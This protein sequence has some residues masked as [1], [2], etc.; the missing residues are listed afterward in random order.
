MLNFLKHQGNFATPPAYH[1]PSG[2]QRRRLC[3]GSDHSILGQTYQ[4][5]ELLIQDNASTDGPRRLPGLARR[6]S[7][8]SYVRTRKTSARCPT[9]IWSSSAPRPLLQMGGAR[10][11]LR[12]DLPRALRRGARCRAGVVLCSGQTRLIN[13]D[14]SPVSYDRAQGRHVTRDR[15]GMLR[16]GRTRSSSAMGRSLP[17]GGPADLD[18]AVRARSLHRDLTEA[19]LPSAHAA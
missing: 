2:F 11:H 9:T 15:S 5:F 1:W 4:D 13:D 19:S 18:Q 12:A 3:S 8:V 6:D 10:R 17:S 14:G 7:R 16:S